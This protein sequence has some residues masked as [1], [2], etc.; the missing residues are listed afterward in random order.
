MKW[1]QREEA[2]SS[3]MKHVQVVQSVRQ[4]CMKLLEKERIESV[5]FPRIGKQN[6]V[7]VHVVTMNSSRALEAKRKS[8]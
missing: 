7:Q 5:K 4:F 1:C 3:H 2:D 6:D 8:F